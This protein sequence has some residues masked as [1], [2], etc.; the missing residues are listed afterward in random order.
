MMTFS[1]IGAATHVIRI[2]DQW[3]NRAVQE[4]INF[5]TTTTPEC[6]EC[7]H[8]RKFPYPVQKLI[9]DQWKLAVQSLADGDEPAGEL[10]DQLICPVD[11]LFWRQY[12]LPCKHLW[13]Y[14]VV[15]DLFREA[16]W[17]AWAEMFEN[18][19]F[20]VYETSARL[21]REEEEMKGP[22]RYALQMRETLD[23]IKEK[24]YEI[25][26]HTADWT[27]EERNPQMQRWLDWLEKLTEPIRSRGVKEALQ[28]LEDE[29]TTNLAKAKAIEGGH[30][31]QRDEDEE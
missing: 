8:F 29:E 2:G 30:K 9:V 10:P 11:C 31:R 23:A 15:F 26:E 5:R 3:E 4:I 7:S 24:Y 27:A 13:H 22:D 28:Q 21:N 25:A 16:D 17:A 12:Q 19:G 18:S 6:Q 14:N 1:L 20:E